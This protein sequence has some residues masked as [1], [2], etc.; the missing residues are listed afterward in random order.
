MFDLNHR[1]LNCL[2]VIWLPSVLQVVGTLLH[3]LWCHLFAFVWDFDV[4]G[5]GM[6]TSVTNF[7]LL[8]LITVG[9]YRIDRIKEA[10][11][12]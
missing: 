1:F 9:S 2:D 12:C 8:L 3:L 11:Y 6:A 10:Y 4:E 7:V 5:L